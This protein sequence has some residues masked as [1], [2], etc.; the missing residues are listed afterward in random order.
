[1][2]KLATIQQLLLRSRRLPWVSVGLT[3]LVLGATILVARQYVR[4]KVREQIIGRDGQVLH[5]VAQMHV[6]EV[7][8]DS[9]PDF[10]QQLT[11]MLKTSRLRGVLGARLFDADGKFL[12][13]FDF[14]VREGALRGSDL[15][16][17]KRLQP[18][19]RF[20]PAVPLSKNFLR[21]A[22]AAD[23]AAPL[24][25]VNIPLHS[26]QSSELFGI[27]QF[28]I[29]GQS[30]ATEFARL[31]RHLTLQSLAAFGVSGAALAAV[32]AWAF[33]R[34]RSAHELLA[35]RTRQLLQAN[36]ELALAAK[37]SALGAVSAHLI[38]GLKNPLSGLQEFV[39]SRTEWPR[40]AEDWEHAVAST[41]RMQG[42]INEVI[43]VLREEE[44]GLRYDVTVAELGQSIA[45]RVE[46][47]A[48]ERGVLFRVQPAGAAVLSNRD[49]NLLTLILVNLVQNGLQSTPA[50]RA[51]WLRLE[52]AEGQLLCEVRDEGPGL[53]EEV[54]QNLFVPCRS[55][56]PGGSGIGLAI[57]KQLANHLGAELSLKSSTGEGCTFLL[58][59]PQPVG[60]ERIPAALTG[61]R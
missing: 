15:P 10:G 55:V 17:L 41:R 11:I 9:A 19:S 22:G 44:S 21:K 40:G 38:H 46:P 8:A 32:L 18:V 24:L 14:D 43:N 36:Q 29:E 35:A 57:S 6:D 16:V 53:P 4:D 48:R 49:A 58:S 26:R 13:A 54:K 30:V 59:L 51:V 37:T 56:R 28:L 52:P 5:A 45:S 42:I 1:M 31:D 27:A 50:G 34:L 12:D 61:P 23:P 20:Q 3:L 47:L 33:R 2:E 7:A 60:A 25:E 39:A